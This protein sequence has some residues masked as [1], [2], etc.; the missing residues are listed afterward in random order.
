MSAIVLLFELVL[1]DSFGLAIKAQHLAI[2]GL[3]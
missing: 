2:I 3:R 1:F